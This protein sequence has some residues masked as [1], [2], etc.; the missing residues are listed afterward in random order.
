MIE[1]GK[2]PNLDLVYVT[3]FIRSYCKFLSIEDA[4]YLIDYFKDL[5]HPSLPPQEPLSPDTE[6]SPSGFSMDTFLKKAQDLSP[7]KKNQKKVALVFFAVL[8]AAVTLYFIF[9]PEKKETILEPVLEKSLPPQPSTIATLPTLL[10]EPEKLE[11]PEE[12]RKSEELE[13]E[14][15]F[16]TAPDTSQ[17]SLINLVQAS[18]QKSKN[19][20]ECA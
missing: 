3:G 10:K 15:D 18:I 4:S 17:K 20:P 9:F 16:S 19:T 5:F 1:A 7:L 6:E 12:A 13:P 14:K 8:F 2:R 11:E